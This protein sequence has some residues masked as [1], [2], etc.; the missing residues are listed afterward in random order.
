MKPFYR[1]R[2]LLMM[3]LLLAA[4]AAVICW[5][6]P[7]APVVAP[8]PEDIQALWDIEDARSESETP[9]VTALENHGVPLAYDAG[10]NTFYC[11]LGLKNEN[12]WPQLHLTA[13]GAKGV[14]LIFAD[15]YSYDWCADA[16]AEGYSYQVMAYT[17]TAF[18]YFDIVF[19]GL[20]I[21]SLD[22][23]Q[24]IT[25]MD[26]PAQMAFSV[27]GEEA[28]R[29]PVR[30]HLRGDRSVTWRP[31]AG[32]KIEFTR[33]A[34]GTGK[35][36]QEVSGLAYTDEALLLPIAVDGTMM[37]DRLSW[38]MVSLAMDESEGFGGL[39]SQYVELFV[40]GS[41]EGIYLMLK[42]FDVADEMEKLGKNSPMTDSLYR[43]SRLEMAKDRPIL[44]DETQPEI[45]FELFHAPDM[46]RGFDALA[47][48]TALLG[49]TDDAAF[50]EKALACI[51]MPSLLRYEL[52]M[53][54]G[55]MVDNALN[56]LY[57]WAHKEGSRF[58]YRFAFWDMDLTWG[59]YAGEDGERWVE[60][61]VADRVI[62]LNPGGE[63]PQMTARIWE[64]M[65]A[66]GF[67]AETVERLITQY[68]HELGDSGA[69]A[70]DAQRWEKGD[71]YPDG[72][73]IVAFAKARFE[74]MDEWVA[75][76]GKTP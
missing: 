76:L 29:S 4:M 35:V 52:I 14:K 50:C 39:P 21:V 69:Y 8:A 58:R 36:S 33:G 34:A 2:L 45:G 25:E 61:P 9:L 11:T 5:A 59:M 47:A 16:I 57:I 48:Y 28:L 65:K 31:K 12:E 30:V 23:Q 20:P 55:G 56:N 10:S 53:Q 70:R 63:I 60:L 7:Y 73:G 74:M 17:D 26:T 13:P 67:T 19:T 43:V 54:A 46:T 22:T 3:A 27:H 66:R 49:E 64:E 68:T 51:D 72:Y 42:P 40:G 38:D 62:A 41:Y 24:T 44:P 1:L 6:S 71:F 32:Y 37:R 15:D 75:S 18:S